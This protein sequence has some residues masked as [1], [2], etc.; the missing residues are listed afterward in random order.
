MVLI[1]T[2]ATIKTHSFNHWNVFVTI[3][4]YDMDR[5]DTTTVTLIYGGLQQNE[6]E[7]EEEDMSTS[8]TQGGFKTGGSTTNGD[9][10]C[11]ST[12]PRITFVQPDAKTKIFMPPSALPTADNRHAVQ[13]QARSSTGGPTPVAQPPTAVCLEIRPR[14]RHL[15]QAE[16]VPH[17]GP[18]LGRLYPDRCQ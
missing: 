3:S 2:I 16:R 4:F 9:P 14:L 17:T 10:I 18:V 15:R 13:R 5:T 12:L 1:N 7:A 11:K 6:E 8:A